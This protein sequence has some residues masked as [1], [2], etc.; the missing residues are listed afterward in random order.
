MNTTRNS[1]TSAISTIIAS[2]MRDATTEG[3]RQAEL[4]VAMY[5]N[6]LHFSTDAI[7]NV[8]RKE[9]S[10]KTEMID[11]MLSD[12]SDDFRDVL[13]TMQS[14]KD[15]PKDEKNAKDKFAID[16]LS[17]KARAARIMF[18]RAMQSVYWLRSSGC[19]SIATNKIGTGALKAK[20]PDPEDAGEYINETYTCNQIASKGN[21][22]IKEVLGKKAKPEAKAKNP[23]ANVIAD[24]S[25]SLSAV[26]T[27]LNADGK[28]KPLTDF[29]DGVEAQL[30]S[31]LHELF[32]MKFAD[33]KG[34][35]HLSDVAAWVNAEFSKP[36]AKA[37]ETKAA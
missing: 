15:K 26:L 7:L 12:F 36:Q 5:A 25:K 1:S 33:D 6:E 11:A 9:G 14:I 16:S 3:N 27:S 28:R 31:T 8:Y 4:S 21:D 22:A 18:E 10:A 32:A 30:E 13:A 20:M 35:V 24:A 2:V 34:I 17:R 37:T 29:A 23:T 19:K